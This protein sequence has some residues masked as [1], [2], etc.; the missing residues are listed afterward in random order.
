[1]VENCSSSLAAYLCEIELWFAS[2]GSRDFILAFVVINFVLCSTAIGF[3]KGSAKERYPW[4]RPSTYPMS[5]PVIGHLLMMAW[6][7]S[8]FLSAVVSVSLRYT[9]DLLDLC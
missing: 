7:S 2:I 1:M 4:R 6:D 3:L 5:V 9:D 8:K